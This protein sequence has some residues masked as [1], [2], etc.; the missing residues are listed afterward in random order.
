MQEKIITY[1]ANSWLKEEIWIKKIDRS[2]I[3]SDYYDF[4]KNKIELETENK[5]IDEEI[6]KLESFEE[7]SKEYK[8]CFD[9]LDNKI[10][11]QYNK[12]KNEIFLKKLFELH[13]FNWTID[14]QKEVMKFV[15]ENY[16]KNW[17]ISKTLQE[18]YIPNYLKK[19]IKNS[20]YPGRKIFEEIFK[21]EIKTWIKEL[22]EY[23]KLDK[24][25]KDDL[26]K[27]L[28]ELEK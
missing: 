1:N 14:S 18:V 24:K 23:E 10:R 21:D 8:E 12:T 15:K 25:T 9:I 6:Q 27:I 19:I 5:I 4:M 17:I 22:L 28:K 7:Q 16:T 20:S 3:S 13:L 2:E 26:E 11:N